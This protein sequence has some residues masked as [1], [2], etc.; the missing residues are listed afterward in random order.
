MKKLPFIIFLF[1]VSCACSS[2][3]NAI[4]LGQGP[5]QTIIATDFREVGFNYEV[6][7]DGIQYVNATPGVQ[8]VNANSNSMK[9]EHWVYR[10]PSLQNREIGFSVMYSKACV[11]SPCDVILFLHG[12]KGSENAGSTLFFDY[13]EENESDRPRAFV[14]ANGIYAPDSPIAS[15]VWKKRTNGDLVFDHPK[16]LV[17]LIGG[18]VEDPNLFPF[19]KT[20]MQHWS[21][22]GFSAGGSGVM[23]VYMDPH[24]ATNSNYQ[25]KHALPLGGWMSDSMNAY[26]DFVGGLEFL[27][28][29]LNEDL[30]LIV[31]NHLAD[32]VDC[33]GKKQ[34]NNKDY[35]V[36]NFTARDIPF[37]YLGLTDEVAPCA[38]GS[39]HNPAHSVKFYLNNAI[40]TALKNTNCQDTTYLDA[41]EVLGDLLYRDY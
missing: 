18:I 17:E 33:V 26:F 16:L 3:A 35:F 24:F 10:S 15:G 21:V 11:N 1:V 27:E 14:F 6:H 20:S 29:C 13:Y 34:F 19:M 22:T 41:Y 36:S 32:D 8:K 39:D 4:D 5:D 25:P 31:A 23:G 30:E 9:G 12:S 28:D 38:L 40:R 7:E 2:D 37:T